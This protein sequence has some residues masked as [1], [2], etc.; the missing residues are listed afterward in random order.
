MSSTFLLSGLV[1][2]LGVAPSLLVYLVGLILALVYRRRYPTPSLLVMIAT[3]LL[4][5]LGVVHS[6][7]V[8]YIVYASIENN[9]TSTRYGWTLFPVGLAANVLHAVGFGLIL[10]AAFVS[11]GGTS[12]PGLKA[13]TE[14]AG[15]PTLASPDT[16]ITSRPP[17]AGG[18]A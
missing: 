5:I 18:P 12:W 9:W 7:V 11:R 14:P 2:L 17:S 10:A 13:P 1:Q 3:A 4:L 8:Q 16:G 15:W 6:F